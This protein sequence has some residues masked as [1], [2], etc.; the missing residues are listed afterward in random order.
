[1]IFFKR[2]KTLVAAFCLIVTSLLILTYN[3][4]QPSPSFIRR[5]IIEI[6]SSLEFGVTSTVSI[7]DRYW[8]RY[9]FLVGLEDENRRLKEQN[10]QLLSELIKYQEGYFEGRRL[11]SLL[12]LKKDINLPALGAQVINK[13][14]SGLFKTITINRGTS[15]GLRAGLPVIASRGIIGRIT[16][17]TWHSSRVLLIIDEN[18]NV[19]ALIQR[20]RTQGI[21]QGAGFAGCNMKY[22]LKTEDVRKGDLVIS[23]GMGGI[24]P[25]EFLLGIVTKVEKGKS[26]LFQKIEVAPTADF[27]KLEEV[28]VLLSEKK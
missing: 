10:A 19:D 2:Y 6:S 23:S 18:S 9:F 4:K 20:T 3:V 24:F 1:M 7:I 5:L 15:G 11:Q 27:S 26:G 12:D 8:H 17:C 14:K 28:L 13:S 25:K 16:E 21:L 22:I